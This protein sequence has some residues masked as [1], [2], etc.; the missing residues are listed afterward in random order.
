MKR[1]PTKVTRD[2]PLIVT[3]IA[4][5]WN[6]GTGTW[7]RF[8]IRRFRKTGD[9]DVAE[10]LR[11]HEHK[12]FCL[13]CLSMDIQYTAPVDGTFKTRCKRCGVTYHTIKTPPSPPKK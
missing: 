9:L 1:R 3:G 12:D 11:V 5:Q 10:L 2:G 4:W 7:D 13:V 8:L 6:E